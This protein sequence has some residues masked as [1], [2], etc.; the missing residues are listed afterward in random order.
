MSARGTPARGADESQ[1]ADERWSDGTPRR[2]ERATSRLVRRGIPLALALTLLVAAVPGLEAAPHVVDPAEVS[3][4]VT[5]QQRLRHE[6]IALFQ[7]A[8]DLP[9][10]RE[11][12]RSAGA[13][14]E[15][16]KAAVPHLSDTE[17]ADIARRA[18]GLADVVAAGD[19]DDHT[20]RA[21]L[22][23]TGVLLIPVGYLV[24]HFIANLMIYS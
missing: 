23:A 6:R 12:A 22:V 17:L 24:L 9:G 18:E 1:G 20:K 19:E 4:R 7:A 2:E 16:L 21:C 15:R 11:Q 3:A 8:L 14:P 5:A 10:V 13:D